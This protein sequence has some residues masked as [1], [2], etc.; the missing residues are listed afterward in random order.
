MDRVVCHVRRVGLASVALLSVAV[1]V[2]A[3]WV[4]A[5]PDVIG[6]TPTWILFGVV[7]LLALPLA[8]VGALAMD[9]KAIAALLPG[10]PAAEP[11]VAQSGDGSEELRRP[12]P[13]TGELASAIGRATTLAHAGVVAHDD[14][15]AR[16]RH[17]R[18]SVATQE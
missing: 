6:K 16:H 1:G 15:S 14:R 2:G 9:R 7:G 10:E 12:E 3:I 5:R 11:I 17:H 13:D 18:A 4:V 8:V